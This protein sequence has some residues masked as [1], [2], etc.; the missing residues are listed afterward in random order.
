MTPRLALFDLDGTLFLTH[1]P[2]SGRA[3]VETLEQS[4]GAVVDP[5]APANVDHRGLTAKRIARNVLRAAGLADPVID[6]GLDRWCPSYAERYLAL[7]AE[8]DTSGWETRPGAA[9]GLAR[10]RDSGIRL[11]LVTGN[12]EP[13]ARARLERLGLSPFFPPGTGSYGCEA[14]DR[15]TL[16]ALALARAGDWPPEATAEIGDTGEDIATAKA[17]GI[18]SI[19]V[20]SPRTDPAELSDADIV[21]EDMDGIVRA[22]LDPQPP[23]RGL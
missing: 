22:L 6:E 23:A 18:T 16:L 9:E 5:D 8:A 4:F 13:I 7:L 15:E 20:S 11:A 10:L 14:E 21:V 19:A 2:L 17:S 3:L 12:P 1:D